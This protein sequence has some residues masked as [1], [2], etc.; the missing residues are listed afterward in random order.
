VRDIRRTTTNSREVTRGSRLVLIPSIS[1]NRFVL[2]AVLG[3]E[4]GREGCEGCEYLWPGTRLLAQ[5]GAVLAV[6]ASYTLLGVFV[7]VRRAQFLRSGLLE[8]KSTRSGPN[9]SET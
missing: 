1:A 7:P 4:M 8:Y 6:G 2:K 3:S 5:L 9:T